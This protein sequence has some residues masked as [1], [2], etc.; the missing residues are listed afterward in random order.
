M[1]KYRTFG[2]LLAFLKRNMTDIANEGLVFA[3]N[4]SNVFEPVTDVLTKTYPVDLVNGIVY[5]VYQFG[6]KGKYIRIKVLI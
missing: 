2:E 6:P 3:V 4:G 1:K 5:G